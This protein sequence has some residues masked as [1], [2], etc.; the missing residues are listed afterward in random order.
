MLDISVSYFSDIKTTLVAKSLETV[1]SCCIKLF[2]SVSDMS[3]FFKFSVIVDVHSKRSL[4][5]DSLVVDVPTVG[6]IL[7]L[8]ARPNAAHVFFR[9]VSHDQVLPIL[10]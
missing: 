2:R 9:H 3:G 1:S 10:L 7:I 6:L 5:V 4:H 8:L